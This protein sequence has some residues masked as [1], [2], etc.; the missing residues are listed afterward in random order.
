MCAFA[1]SA[2]TME[3]VPSGPRPHATLLCGW[4]RHGK[5]TLATIFKGRWEHGPAF[6]LEPRRVFDIA[7]RTASE[8]AK[9]VADPRKADL[10]VVSFADALK[11]DTLVWLG[12]GDVDWRDLEPVKDT[13]CFKHPA[14]NGDDWVRGPERTLRAH[15]IAF[16]AKMRATDTDYWCKRALA[17]I[18][19]KSTP[20]AC[21]LVTDC[22]FANEVAFM[23]KALGK[24]HDIQTM[25][26][27]RQEAAIPPAGVETEHQL[28]ALVTDFVAVGAL[29]HIDST[30]LGA[31]KAA[32]PQYADYVQ[33]RD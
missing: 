16:G 10:V 25:R 28:D 4:T 17:T 8:R 1:T 11:Q 20:G 13:A 19:A 18:Q 33:I 29:E 3:D 30:D 2:T 5:D 24:T 26:V 12:M 32:L 6:R 22:R 23:R 27:F 14:D 21:V 7:G 15:Y 9:I 31:V